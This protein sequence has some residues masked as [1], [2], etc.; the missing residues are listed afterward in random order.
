M[1]D[2]FTIRIEKATSQFGFHV[3]AFWTLIMCYVA[4]LH[5]KLIQRD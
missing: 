2:S 1:N 3:N 5:S 4:V